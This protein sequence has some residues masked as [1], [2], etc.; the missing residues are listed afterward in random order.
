MADIPRHLHQLWRDDAVP[1]HLEAL[2]ASWLRHNPGWTATLW[3]DARLRAL[4]AERFPELL[5]MFDGYDA[6]ISRADLGRYL[7]LAV[8]GGI[9]ADLDC[10]CLAPFDPL[11]DGAEL[12]I[13]IEPE[14]HSRLDAAR[15]RRLPRV[16]CPSLLAS[17]PGHP[18]WSRLARQAIA[19]RDAADVLDATGPYL[20]TSA[21]A[22]YPGAA[23]TR[24]LPAELVYPADKDDCWSGRIHDLEFRDRVTRGAAMLHYWDG[25]WFRGRS[26]LA[27]GLPQ[28]AR[29][30]ITDP[31]AA[32]AEGDVSTVPAG[33][34]PAGTA[35]VS[36][37]MVTRGRAARAL[38]AIEC[39]RRQTHDARELVIVDDDP[40]DSLARAVAGLGD[41]SIRHIRL[42]DRGQSLGELRNLAVEAAR[43]SHV[44]QWDDDDLCHPR[45]IEVQLRVLGRAGA[46]ACL[47]SRWLIWWPDRERLAVGRER[48]W[49]GSLLAAREALPRYPALRTGEDTAVLDALKRTHRVVRLDLPGL[50]TYVVHGANAFGAEHFE[51]HWALATARF[52]GE[53]YRAARETLARG[54]PLAQ[55]E[56]VRPP[57]ATGSVPTPAVRT[58]TAEAPKVLVL[59]PV[60]DAVRH[61]PRHIDLLRRLDYDPGRLSLGFIEGDST[62][63]TYEALAA[64]LP[65]LR[66]R[67]RWVTLARHDT[68]FRAPGPRWAPAIQRGR[69]AALAQVRNR[70][71]A[72]ALRDEDWVL[73]LDVDLVDYP[74]DLLRRMLAAGKQVAAARCVLPD[75]RDYDLNSFAVT[76]PA[77]AEGEDPRHLLDGIFQPPPG[78]GRRYLGDLAGGGPV[79]LDGVGGTALL[80]RADLHRDGLN[81]PSYPYK[82][83]IETEGLARMARD[84]GIDCWGLPDLRVVHA[85]GTA[86]VPPR[87]PR[88]EPPTGQRPPPARVPAETAVVDASV[89]VC[90]WRR[91]ALLAALLDSLLVQRNPFG[92]TEVVVVDNCEIEPA[93]AVVAD[94]AGVFQAAGMPIRRVAERRQGVSHARN[95]GVAEAA[96]GVIAFID[97]DERAQ[98]GWLETLLAPFARREPHV[99]MVGGEVDPDF[100]DAARPPWLTD[101]LL[102]IY[103]CRWGWD[104]EPR[105]L[106]PREWFGEGNCALRAE[107]FR[108]RAFDTGLGRSGGSLMG[109]EGGLFLEMREQGA[110]AWFEPRARVWH[111]VHPE[112]LSKRWMLR[113]MLFQGMSDCRAERRLATRTRIQPVSIDL[114]KFGDQDVEAMDA[115][116]TAAMTY[117]Y[118]SLGYVLASNF[119]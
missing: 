76:G 63:G 8:H 37:L 74:A 41:P 84:M 65:D 110:R 12:V 89:V 82:G 66:E 57:A 94:R 5:G 54:L 64:R 30:R 6:P 60:R 99:D 19:A 73:W 20:L 87:E 25:S 75:G 53:R 24:L 111:R 33:D 80:V 115:R 38:A 112:R 96:H 92:R 1:P 93:E 10:E 43:G 58:P 61:L 11:L 83:Y 32:E 31:A 39:Y 107:L 67:F 91:P 78:V 113:R 68:G 50:Y 62:D 71:L 79:R 23:A 22:G 55:A 100:G 118:Y 117:L 109:S 27:F 119:E 28:S 102:Q 40:D 86:P 69:R 114:A 26:A 105:F 2:R 44:C 88:P 70:L 49:E 106:R 59:T 29:V 14:S 34:E 4:V 46:A 3:T 21:H 45:R 90:T 116:T 47:L 13:G 9:Y 77:A 108:G 52:E 56:A 18:F 98:P 51:K 7:V 72:A 85:A 97:D 35:L 36:C 17:V 81:F 104:T 42:P 16:L 103:S 15:R 101:N 95:R 48:D